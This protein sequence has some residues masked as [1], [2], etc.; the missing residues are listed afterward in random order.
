M[1]VVKLSSYL[2]V[3]KFIAQVLAVNNQTGDVAASPHKAFWSNLTYDQFVGGNVPGVLD[4]NTGNPMPILVK[5]N[6][7]RSNII[8]ALRGIGPIFNSNGPFGQ[9]PADGPP[10][11]TDDQISSI[12]NWIDANCPQ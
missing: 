11:F 7:A 9:M 1:A 12:A 3:Q 5:A 8:M 2:E 10:F 6:S 4:P